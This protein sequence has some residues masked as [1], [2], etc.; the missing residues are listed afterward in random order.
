MRYKYIP[1]WNLNGKKPIDTSLGDRIRERLKPKFVKRHTSACKFLR[2]VLAKAI[3]EA[4]RGTVGWCVVTN[5]DY[6][7]LRAFLRKRQVGYEIDHI[8]PLSKINGENPNDI[9]NLQW[10]SKRANRMKGA[11]IC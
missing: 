9:N 2:C 7:T 4:K 3:R 6:D 8:F 5:C 10:L 11:K 1:T